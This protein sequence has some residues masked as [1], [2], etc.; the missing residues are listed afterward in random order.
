MAS[1]RSAAAAVA[2]AVDGL[3]PREH[4]QQLLQVADGQPA[5]DAKQ[6]VRHRAKNVLRQQVLLQLVDVGPQLLDHAEL[7]FRDAEHQHVDLAPVLGKVGGRLVGEKVP[8]RWAISSAPRMELWSEMV[9]KSMP[10]RRRALVNL[11]GL[12]KTLRRADAAQK[13]FTRPVRMLAVY[14]EVGLRLLRTIHRRGP[15]FCGKTDFETARG[16]EAILLA[17]PR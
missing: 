3:E 17:A 11:Q 9:T 14:V 7:I 2:R 16:T 5:V 4:H 8:G 13:P 1:T 15:S 12:D 10:R 6:R